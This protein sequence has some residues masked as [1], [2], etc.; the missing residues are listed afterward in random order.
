MASTPY[1]TVLSGRFLATSRTV[2][3]GTLLVREW[4][5]IVGPLAAPR[6]LVDG[7]PPRRTVCLGCHCVLPSVLPARGTC[8]CTSCGA[9]VCDK[10]CEKLAAHSQWECRALSPGR[11]KGLPTGLPV[12]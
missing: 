4:P 3:A 2:P 10:Q 1:A 9:P 7:Q 5:L 11:G 12:N 6:S 8:S